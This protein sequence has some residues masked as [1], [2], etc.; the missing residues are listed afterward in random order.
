MLARPRSCR[1]SV[2]LPK[3]Q[4]STGDQAIKRSG[5]VAYTFR[6][7]ASL[8][9]PPYQI[10][11]ESSMEV[12]DIAP[13]VSYYTDSSHSV[14]STGLVTSLFSPIM[15]V[16][17]FMIP[18]DLRRETTRNW[19]SCRTLFDKSPERSDWQRD[20]MQYGLDTRVFTIAT[21]DAHILRYCIPMDNQRPELD[22]KH[23]KD[24]CPD[25]NGASV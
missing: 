1:E 13:S 4:L 11:L 15:M 19:G 21:T 5:Y 17:F 7:S 2:T 20:Y 25:R 3:V 24:I 18:A 14:A 8:V 12:S 22:L 6:N 23:F 9:L 16:I 10:R